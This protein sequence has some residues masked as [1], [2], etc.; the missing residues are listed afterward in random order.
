[1]DASEVTWR[2]NTY[3][4]LAEN[5]SDSGEPLLSCFCLNVFD[6]DTVS[7]WVRLLLVHEHNLGEELFVV[8]ISYD[9]PSNLW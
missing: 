1:M 3:T 5:T 6:G 7:M 4:R 2:K 9:E 8:L